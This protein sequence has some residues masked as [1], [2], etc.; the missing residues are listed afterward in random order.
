MR[1]VNLFLILLIASIAALIAATVVGFA[2]FSATSQNNPYGWMSQM[3]NG[4]SGTSGNGYGGMGG[5]MGQNPTATAAATNTM[6]PYF[7]AIFAVLIGVTVIG[8]G[9]VAY[10]LVYPQMKMGAVVTA[11]IPSQ[12]TSAAYESVAKTLTED[13]RKIVTVLQAHEGK[14]LQKYIKSETGLSRLQTH[15]IIARLSERGIVSIEKTGNTNQ[16]YLANWLNQKQ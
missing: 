2:I 14:Y 5:M 4:N 3:W 12:P 13:E 1:R 8:V 9:G 16:V 7:G 6:L 11:T 15:R 10:Y